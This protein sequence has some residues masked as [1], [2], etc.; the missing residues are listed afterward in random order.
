MS[1]NLAQGAPTLK[2]VHP[3]LD[4]VGDTL[5]V[6]LRVQDQEKGV[7]DAILMS[8]E[9]GK[10]TEAVTP[11]A[12]PDTCR[13]L[14]LAPYA[15]IDLTHS[16]PASRWK[17]DSIQALLDGTLTAPDFQMVYDAITAA[18]SDR[19]EVHRDSYI[20]TLALWAMM[21]Y[22][23]PLWDEMPFLH[24]YG[25]AESGK[26]RALATL[27]YLSFNGTISDPTRSVVFRR[28]HQGRHTQVIPEADGFALKGT[29]DDFVRQLQSSHS[30]TEAF[31]AVNETTAKGGKYT[32]T[33]YYSYSPRAFGSTKEFKSHPL[34][35]RCIRLTFR[36]MP[37][38]DEQK[39]R[40]SLADDPTWEDLRDM[41][42]RLLFVRWQEVKEA[43]E[44]VKRECKAVKGRA[45]NKWLPLLTVARLVSPELYAQVTEWAQ[46]DMQAMQEDTVDTFH[47]A[48]MLFAAHLVKS[49]DTPDGKLSTDRASIYEWWQ[50]PSADSDFKPLWAEKMGATVTLEQ[51]R[52]WVKGPR[53]L[54]EELTS[55]GL[56]TGPTH[57]EKGNRYALDKET[58]LGVA[59]AYLGNDF[60]K[61]ESA[62]T[63]PTT[64]TEHTDRKPALVGAGAVWKPEDDDDEEDYPF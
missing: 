19:L 7:I 40:R 64:A 1:L 60:D 41:L 9:S 34:R 4:I 55:L 50:M 47:A 48:L 58:V 53:K 45:F 59:R 14:S 62:S 30:K 6:G 21:T 35:T 15:D 51:V 3:A 56:A 54:M 8:Q 46:E 18:L 36:K 10:L 28:A 23:Q 32:P 49:S 17:N 20:P 42:Y 44:Q 38:A 26:S 61:N 52:R 37:N 5:F 39:L 16:S 13:A 12:W 27:A 33:T 31:V 11:D 63:S 24:A 29:D 57:T 25:P 2:H 22:L 43:K